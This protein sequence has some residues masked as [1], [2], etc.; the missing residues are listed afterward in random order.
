MSRYPAQMV[1]RACAVFGTLLLMVCAARA[2]PSTIV[3]P[4]PAGQISDLIARTVGDA[5]VRRGAPQVI[6][7]N[8]AGASGTIAVQRVLSAAP[9][10]GTVLLGSPNELILAPLALGAARHKA[11]DL[12]LL[13]MVASTPLVLVC[14][15]DLATSTDELVA[16]ARSA[17]DRRPLNYGSVGMGS[18]LHL[19]GESLSKAIGAQLSHVP[20]K[21]GAPLIQDL[22]GGRLDFA[23]VPYSQQLQGLADQGRIRLLGT[24]ARSRPAVL[25]QVPTMNEGQALRDF[26]FEIWTGLAV[27]NDVPVA[28]R[29]QWHKRFAEVLEDQQVRSILEGQ[30]L[31]VARPMSL[32]ALS[33]LYAAETQRYRALAAAIGLTPQ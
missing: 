6:V 24:A 10:S 8:L 20:Y 9:G 18:L 23:L 22:A 15:P 29:D 3:V 17:S 30:A 33:A 12:Q 14:R 11:E 26:A 5:L 13:A 7:E 16:L 1:L 31:T 2:Q 21:G 4:Y 32:A 27:G 28:Q 25:A 19:M